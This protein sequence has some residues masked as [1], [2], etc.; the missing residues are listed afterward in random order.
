[1]RSLDRIAAWWRRTFPGELVRVINYDTA[2]FR[3]YTSGYV[4]YVNEH[5]QKIDLYVELN[6]TKY[7]WTFRT[8]DGVNIAS[9]PLYRDEAQVEAKRMVGPVL[10]V[11]DSLKMIVCRS[12]N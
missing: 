11:D 10:Y 1:M 8:P 4:E 3:Q 5:N 12:R 9:R 6:L 2:M 7:V